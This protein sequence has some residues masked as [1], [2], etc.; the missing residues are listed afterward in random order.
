MAF[1]VDDAH[2]KQI[3]GDMNPGEKTGIRA[4]GKQD[5]FSSPTGGSALYLGN[6]APT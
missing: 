5:G 2:F 6:Q 1:H 3:G 4:D